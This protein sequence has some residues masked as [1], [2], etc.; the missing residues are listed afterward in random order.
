MSNQNFHI[1]LAQAAW[2]RIFRVILVFGLRQCDFTP[3]LSINF[4]SLY[5]CHCIFLYCPPPPLSLSLSLSLSPSVFLSLSLSPPPPPSFTPY[6]H[7]ALWVELVD[8]FLFLEPQLFGFWFNLLL[9]LHSPAV[10]LGFT[11]FG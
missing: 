10:S 11:I 6:L 2:L 3:S 1:A 8:T 9:L 4:L 5:Y 7:R